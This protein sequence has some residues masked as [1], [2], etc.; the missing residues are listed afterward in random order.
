MCPQADIFERSGLSL[1]TS[2]NRA[3]TISDGP[4]SQQVLL[5]K[6]WQAGLFDRTAEQELSL[7]S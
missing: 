3:A 7:G 5:K 4:V 2:A 1:P 6:W